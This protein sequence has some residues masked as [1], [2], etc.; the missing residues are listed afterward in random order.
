MK[1][2]WTCALRSRVAAIATMLSILACTGMG[3][4]N[5]VELPAVDTTSTPEIRITG[6]VHRLTLEGGLF[7]IL[8]TAGTQYNPSN[9][10]PAFQVDS[11]PVEADARQR[12]DL[13]SIG[14]VGPMVDLVR[15]RRRAASS[16]APAQP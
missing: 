16:P 14:M 2:K 9:L 5:W 8:D 4:A 12:D 10:P 1:M 7:V 13:M 11:L 6:T 15:I 3:E